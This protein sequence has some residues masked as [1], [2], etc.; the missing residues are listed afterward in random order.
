MR[1]KILISALLALPAIIAAEKAMAEE[2]VIT[3][4]DHRFSPEMLVIPSG[5][6]VKLI[7]D[8]QDPTPEEFESYELNREKIIS[9][10]KKGTVFVGPLKPGTYTYFGEFHQ[11]TAKG[12]ITAK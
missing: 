8:N 1:A 10:N 3:I 12:K 5:E 2:Y 6:K 7:I 9:G 4:K 11:E